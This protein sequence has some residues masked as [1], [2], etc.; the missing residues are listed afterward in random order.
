[1]SDI[2]VIVSQEGST[3]VIIGVGI[4]LHATTH[5]SGNVDPIDHNLLSGLQGGSI[6]EYYHLTAE[7]YDTVTGVSDHVSS[8]TFLQLSTLIP[9]GLEETGILFGQTFSSIPSVQ[10][11]LQTPYE[12]TYLVGIKEITTTGFTASFSDL[13]DNTG[14]YLQ[15]LASNFDGS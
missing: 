10:V 6:G 4:G 8:S 14:F 2:D 12:Y 3:D 7:Q 11:S 9:S 5:T 1:M 13:I 15:T